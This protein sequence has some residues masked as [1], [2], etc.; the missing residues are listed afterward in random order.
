MFYKN[1]S[2]KS[3]INKE[4]NR[5]KKKI[6]FVN[7]SILNVSLIQGCTMYICGLY[8]NNGKNADG[9]TVDKPYDRGQADEYKQ[10]FT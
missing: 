1:L 4:N 8:K 10:T 6:K 7:E 3:T 2:E 9:L 5:T